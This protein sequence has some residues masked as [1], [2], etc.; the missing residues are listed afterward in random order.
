MAQEQE[1]KKLNK[2]VEDAVNILKIVVGNS[3]QVKGMNEKQQ[4]AINKWFD[5]VTTEEDN[6]KKQR[7]FTEREFKELIRP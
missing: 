2:T 5:V 1:L 7:A 6:Q 3:A 4:Q